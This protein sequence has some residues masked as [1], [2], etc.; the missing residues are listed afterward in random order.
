MAWKVKNVDPNKKYV[1]VI[2]ENKDGQLVERRLLTI[3]GKEAKYYG[4][5]KNDFLTDAKGNVIK[6]ADG[7]PKKL[8]QRT[9]GRMEG[10]ITRGEDER[11]AYNRKL[12]KSKEEN[13]TL[14]RRIH[15]STRRTA[16]FGISDMLLKEKFPGKTYNDLKAKEK[17]SLKK[18]V[19]A[20]KE[21]QAIK[22]STK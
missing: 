4:N 15:N 19:Y 14:M 8:S 18:A 13:K 3:K 5:L 22:E 6:G 20:S 9:K 7:K 16:Y 10:Y 1:D 2:G 12:G 17:E 11:I 21:W